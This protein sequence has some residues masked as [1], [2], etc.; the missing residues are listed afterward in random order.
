M[1]SLLGPVVT[2]L[3]GTELSS[4]EREW[5][6][7]P[8]VGGLIFFARNYSSVN[9]LIDLV[10]AVRAIRP[11]LILMVDQEGGRVQRFKSG[12]TRLPPLQ[13]IGQ[14]LSVSSDRAL[15][16]ARQHG[17]LMA[18]EVLSVGIDLSLAPVLDCDFDRS[19][20][21]G[22]RAFSAGE[23]Q[24]ISL[25]EAYI[26]GMQQAGMA[27]TGKHF[28]GHGLVAHDSHL[29]LPDSDLSL[30]AVRDSHMRVFTALADKLNGIMPA[31]IV[32]SAVDSRPVGFSKRWLQSILR[33]QLGFRGVIFSDDLAMEGAGWAGGYPE[34]AEA[35]LT[36]GCDLVLVCNQPA[37]ARQVLEHLSRQGYQGNSRLHKLKHKFEGPA[38][39]PDSLKPTD[40][41][42]E[43]IRHL[44]EIC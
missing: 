17:W 20:V 22:D 6:L 33:E 3:Q 9:Q 30:E 19:E 7:H 14:Q 27:A 38:L 41:W 28:P 42:R 40:R 10:G 36:A 31:H 13:K 43:C 18:S 2:D 5:L 24:V 15:S 35:A 1:T 34:R 26:E 4:Q 32:F 39:G 16:L 25:A 21:I 29:T 12:F 23:E 44:R 8:A 11:E 37:G